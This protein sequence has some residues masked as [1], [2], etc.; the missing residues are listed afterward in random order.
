MSFEVEKTMEQRLTVFAPAVARSGFAGSLAC[1]THANLLRP[2]CW[3]Q[4]SGK[5]D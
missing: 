1:Y 4:V 2:P 5:N 3:Q